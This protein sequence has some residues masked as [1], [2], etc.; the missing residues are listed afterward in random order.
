MNDY[1]EDFKYIE[2]YLGFKC[3][4]RCS[5]CDVD[6]TRIQEKH[7]LDKLKDLID[8]NPDFVNYEKFK[9][10][11]SGG[12]PTL[13]EEEVLDI[14]K[15]YSSKYIF[16][17]VSN[18]KNIDTLLKYCEYPIEVTIS[19]D[20]HINDRGFDS[21]D[22][23]KKIHKTGRLKGVNIVISNSN[24]KYL[25]KTCK[26]LVDLY[27]YLISNELLYNN[28]L[29][30]LKMEI[31]RFDKTRYNF[32][33]N[34]FR[35]QIEL[36]YRHISK[37]LHIFKKRSK[38][39]SNFW[40]FNNHLITSHNN[41]R[42]D[43][44]GCFERCINPNDV[45]KNYETFCAKCDNYLCYA[46][47]CPSIYEVI[48][49]CENN[50]YCELNKIIKDVKEKVDMEEFLKK[51]LNSMDYIELILTQN[52]NLN[53][54]H[55]FE[56]SFYNNKR[57][58]NVMTKETI[59]RIFELMIDNRDDDKIVKLNLFGGEP[60][61]PSTLEIRKYI[62]KK[63]KESKRKFELTLVSNTY[64]ITEADIEW[65][66]E[67]K[68]TVFFFSWQVSVD[69]IAKYN[70]I[71]RV[72]YD[73]KGTFNTVINNLK[74][75]SPI[76]GKD[77]I[78]INS[79]ITFDNIDGLN[80]WCQYISNELLFKYITHVTFRIDQTRMD[81]L[82]L[83]ERCKITEVYMSLVE[84]YKN[85]LIAP[86]VMRR[87]FNIHIESY[88]YRNEK[89]PHK[90]SCGI[91]NNQITIDYNGNLMPCHYF[92]NK[93][94]V[95]VNIHDLNTINK[96]IFKIYNELGSNPEHYNKSTGEKCSECIYRFNCVRCKIE[97]MQNGNVDVVSEFN[98]EWVKQTGVIYD[99]YLWDVFKPMS[100]DEKKDF[101][102]NLDE[103]RLL[104]IET[105][106]GTEEYVEL[107]KLTR[108]F[109]ILR[110]ERIW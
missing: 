60:I 64:N 32:D 86:E 6:K 73:E 50:Q 84:S 80:D 77:K 101:L 107:L 55:C 93:D 34:I 28:N 17:I 54:K 98:C 10:I 104:F 13:F 91:C 105:K 62:L 72:T 65:I 48:G 2:F 75:L 108:M 7:G 22:S 42:V 67:A 3:N 16:H 40:F 39:C 38:L 109:Y 110:R 44:N 49:S 87:V 18:G 1:Y 23:I 21:F 11:L 96:N 76:I 63:I 45:I 12:E 74:T 83:K 26:E 66:K 31:V 37:E 15:Y 59:D 99:K 46:K 19:Y 5:Y 53:C 58:P 94:L 103:I 69:S 25:Y 82:T 4:L 97:Q 61:L 30:G 9:I 35:H 95:I 14:L 81:N 88:L 43:E 56:H 47:T 33:L 68:D 89:T 41:G 20:G 29:L 106:E 71:T 102:K 27:P 8:K 36:I 90:L 24:Y 79:V 52:C 85:G 92:N 70:D 78:N 57:N 100:E 51:Q